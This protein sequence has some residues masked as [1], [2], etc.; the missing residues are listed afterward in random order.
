MADYII[1]ADEFV[2]TELKTDYM[3]NLIG[4]GWGRF[5][6]NYHW[7]A[8]YRTLKDVVLKITEF[9]I[10]NNIPPDAAEWGMS[11]MPFI[12]ET[13]QNSITPIMI[14]INEP[15]NTENYARIDI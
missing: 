11:L 10:K 14:A 12:P 15:F 5:M 8:S 9:A 3:G 6:G 13:G 1:K 2:I 4:W 7:D